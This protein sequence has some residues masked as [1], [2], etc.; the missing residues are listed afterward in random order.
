MN[1]IHITRQVETKLT[2]WFAR[3][4]NSDF[5]DLVFLLPMY[6]VMRLWDRI[7]WFMVDLKHKTLII[8]F[9]LELEKS[10]TH[11]YAFH[12]RRYA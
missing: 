3:K 7:N 2:A 1:V 8:S 9:H 11:P 4:K 5:L 6:G 10:S 12:Y